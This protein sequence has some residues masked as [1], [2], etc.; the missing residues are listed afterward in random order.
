MEALLP[1]PL[2][3][4]PTF[5]SSLNIWGGDKIGIFHIKIFSVSGQDSE[6]NILSFQIS[7]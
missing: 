3:P 2:P 5:L 6:K 7:E 1:L 4:P